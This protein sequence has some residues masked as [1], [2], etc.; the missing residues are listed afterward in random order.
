MECGQTLVLVWNNRT[1]NVAARSVWRTPT[2]MRL[3]VYLATQHTK[4]HLSNLPERLA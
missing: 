2:G 1:D 4:P 3:C